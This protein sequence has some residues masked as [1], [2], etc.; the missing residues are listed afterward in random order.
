M[1]I[2]MEQAIKLVCKVDDLYYEEYTK[3]ETLLGNCPLGYPGFPSLDTPKQ[4]LD[5][6]KHRKNQI[7]TIRAQIAELQ[8]ENQDSI[9]REIVSICEELQ[10]DTSVT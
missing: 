3:R 2:T 4:V 1:C 5:Y 10:I 9:S 8:K 7:E 6:I